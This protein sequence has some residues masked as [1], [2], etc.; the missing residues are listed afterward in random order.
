MSANVFPII[1]KV[2]QSPDAFPENCL[3]ESAAIVTT[4]A[5]NG[6]CWTKFYILLTLISY[7]QAAN[8]HIACLS[9]FDEIVE[10]ISK[11]G[12]SS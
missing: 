12:L 11:Y 5:T 7:C 4:V 6:I 2:L 8:I 10:A 3:M 9:N 1:V